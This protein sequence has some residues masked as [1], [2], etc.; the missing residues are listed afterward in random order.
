MA[1]RAAPEAMAFKGDLSAVSKA[2]AFAVSL[3]PAELFYKKLLHHIKRAE[4]TLQQGE[5]LHVVHA[6]PSGPCD[7]E[8]IGYHGAD[9][10]ILDGVNDAGSKCRLLVHLYVVNLAVTTMKQLGPRRRIGFAGAL[11]QEPD[12]S[13]SSEPHNV[14]WCV[15][16]V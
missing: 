7:V 12:P 8:N 2:P 11:G 4:A 3:N 9:M 13:T 16:S 10:L 15:G 14:A 1:E 5:A 6:G